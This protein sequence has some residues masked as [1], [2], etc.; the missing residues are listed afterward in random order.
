MGGDGHD[1]AGAVIGEDKVR[2]VDRH[3]PPRDRVQ[4]IRIEEDALL[5]VGFG[6]PDLLV[7]FF[8]L[9]HEITDRSFAALSADELHHER[10][11]GGDQHEGGAEDRVLASREDLDRAVPVGHREGSLA[12]VALSD[13]VP[14][15]RKDPLGPAGETVA[16]VEEFV[17]VGGDP[18]EPLVQ[19]LLS[20]LRAATPAEA[21]LHLLVGEDRL[22]LGAP[23]HRGT[24]LVGEPLFKHPKE[25]EL[26]PLVIF[27]FAGCELPVP[28][29]AEAHPFELAL[30]VF[31]VFMGPDGGVDAPFDGG[32]L[33]RHA[34]GVPAHRMED[35]E[36]LHSLVPGNDVSDRVVPHM[37]DVDPAGGVREHLE[38]IVFLFIR[39]FRHLEDLLLFPVLLPLFFNLYGVV[40]SVHASLRCCFMGKTLTGK[41]ACTVEYQ[42]P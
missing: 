40:L 42:S 22:A 6:G 2:R 5:L 23:V 10:M 1:A 14:L 7:L 12:A 13:P 16:V 15:H 26:L 27:G 38:K 19:V 29:I 21:R 20:D 35:V 24:L 37:A 36:P 28:V 8:D 3:F 18:E 11:F 41:R 9:F 34:E 17:D 30:H 4:A 25:E 32:V 33:R 31:D 39:I